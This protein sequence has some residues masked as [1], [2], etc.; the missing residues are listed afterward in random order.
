VKDSTY[1]YLLPQPSTVTGGARGKSRS[2]KL[3][4]E[5]TPVLYPE[6]GLHSKW[7]SHKTS[8]GKKISVD[9]DAPVNFLTENIGGDN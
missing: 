9:G 3:R 7:R 8:S 2:S 6:E 4:I 5:T 1:Y